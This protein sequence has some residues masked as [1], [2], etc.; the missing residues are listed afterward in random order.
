MKV[1][2]LPPD[3]KFRTLTP[4]DEEIEFSFEAKKQALGLHIRLKWGWDEKFQREVHDQR[5]REK[6]FCQIELNGRPIGT[7][8][9]QRLPEFIRFGE[10]YLID[11]F[12]GLGI[13]SRILAH[14]LKLAD[15]KNLPVE[16]QPLCPRATTI[17]AGFQAAEVGVLFGFSG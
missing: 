9:L 14:C 13:G 12:R 17:L 10:F 3:V 4:T 15:D 8:S 7:L 6:P 5:L 16:R 1:P 11:S 2:D